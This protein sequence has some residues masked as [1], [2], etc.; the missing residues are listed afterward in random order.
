L[1]QDSAF[2]HVVNAT[3]NIDIAIPCVRL[4]ARDTP[5]L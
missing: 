5:E 4:F 2:I 1:T 3:D